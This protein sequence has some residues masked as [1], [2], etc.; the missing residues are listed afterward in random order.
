[1]MSVSMSTHT[2]RTS[3]LFHPGGK[4]PKKSL[5]HR[6]ILS[7]PQLINSVGFVGLSW[8]QAQELEL[9]KTLHFRSPSFI[10]LWMWSGNRGLQVLLLS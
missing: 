6:L 5:Q 7:N 3:R 4:I 10:S 9:A 8:H 2:S 1:M